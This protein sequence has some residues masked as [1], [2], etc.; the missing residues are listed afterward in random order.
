MIVGYINGCIKNEK[1]ADSWIHKRINVYKN[2]KLAD[3]E[4]ERYEH[5]CVGEVN[6]N[7]QT[8]K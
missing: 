3:G 6:I 2:E 4:S 5:M 8:N 1:L 7:I